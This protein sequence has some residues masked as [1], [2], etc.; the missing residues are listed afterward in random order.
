VLGRQ[1]RPAQVDRD[2][3]IEVVGLDLPDRCLDGPGDAG[4][5][6][7]DVDPSKCFTRAGDQ[8]LHC[9]LVGDVGRHHERAAAERLDLAREGLEGRGLARGERQ[10]RAFAG[11]RQTDVAAHTL[12]GAGDDGDPVGELHP[13]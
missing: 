11:Q 4:R 13:L 5:V 10:V 7:E 3:L 6:D 9:G 2:D 8:A 12:G 1:E